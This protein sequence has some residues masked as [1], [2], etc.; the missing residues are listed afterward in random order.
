MTRITTGMTSVYAFYICYLFFLTRALFTETYDWT[1]A[2][3]YLDV[4]DYS[5]DAYTNLTIAAGTT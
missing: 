1:G 2:V 5:E 4:F 3:D